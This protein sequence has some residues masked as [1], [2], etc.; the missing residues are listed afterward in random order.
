MRLGYAFGK[1]MIL[2]TSKV[3]MI[4]IPFVNGSQPY[5]EGKFAACVRHEIVM[6]TYD[7]RYT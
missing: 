4:S 6:N 1:E 3:L 7:K 2:D 5:E